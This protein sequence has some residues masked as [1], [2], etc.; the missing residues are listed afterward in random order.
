MELSEAFPIALA[1]FLSEELRLLAL[2]AILWQ[3]LTFRVRII[4]ASM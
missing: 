1:V 2:F 3:P 4:C